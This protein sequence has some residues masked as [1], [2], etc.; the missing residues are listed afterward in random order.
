MDLAYCVVPLIALKCGR[1][2]VAGSVIKVAVS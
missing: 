2:P 1:T